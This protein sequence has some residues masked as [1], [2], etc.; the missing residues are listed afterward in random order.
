MAKQI[1]TRQGL[2]NKLRRFPDEIQEH[3]KHLESLI[4]DYPLKVALGY[5]FF[6]L[7]LGQNMALYCGIVKL[8]RANSTVARNAINTHHMTR[9]KFIE[10]YKTIYDIELPEKAR[11]DLKIAER[12]RDTVMHGG[13]TTDDRLRNA[14]SLVLEYTIA[15]NRQLYKKSQIK[16]FSGSLRGFAGRSKKLDPN[17]TR[18]MLKGMGFGIA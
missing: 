11:Q 16:P 6:R 5:V 13:E 17:I 10:L 8:H 12:T 2:I 7:E 4:N 14:I 9:Q 3:F 18:F 15:V 1:K